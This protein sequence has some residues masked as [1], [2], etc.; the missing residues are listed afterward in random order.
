MCATVL[1]LVP[2]PLRELGADPGRPPVAARH[3]LEAAPASSRPARARVAPGPAARDRGAVLDARPVGRPAER[4]VVPG[5][6]GDGRARSAPSTALLGCVW[7]A[8]LVV[9]VGIARACADEPEGPLED[10]P[11]KSTAPAPTPPRLAGRDG[12]RA[13]PALKNQKPARSARRVGRRP[14]CGGRGHPQAQRPPAGGVRGARSSQAGPDGSVRPRRARRRY[15]ARTSPSHVSG[16][17]AAAAAASAA[18]RPPA[19]KQTSSS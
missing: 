15:P 19:A 11:R 13:R 8:M 3:P 4:S 10:R 18:S 2:Q 9:V 17:P 1:V 16:S 7:L 12:I 14:A 6:A 5:P